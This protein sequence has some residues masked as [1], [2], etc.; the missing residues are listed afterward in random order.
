[1]ALNPETYLSSI[2]SL[3]GKT[4]L[5]TGAGGGI[6]LAISEGLLTAAS[7]RARTVVEEF[8][9]ALPGA[10]DYTIRVS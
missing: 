1:M 6:G 5:V 3:K 9:T 8:I 2:F 4:I 7:E 10:E